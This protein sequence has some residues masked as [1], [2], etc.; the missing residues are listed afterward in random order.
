[1]CDIN[2][3]LDRLRQHNLKNTPKRREILRLFLESGTYH[4][5]FDIHQHLKQRFGKTGLPTVY[6]ILHEFS[7]IG[8][9]KLYHH[10]DRQLYYY[11]CDLSETHHHHFFCIECHRVQ[12]VLFCE[13]DALRNHAAETLNAD[14]TDHH[15]EIEGRCSHC[16]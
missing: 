16:R 2:M 9:L 14:V 11:F 1:M 7:H 6:R 4:S 15:L 12:T 3:Y 13:F 5:P 10:P 8:L